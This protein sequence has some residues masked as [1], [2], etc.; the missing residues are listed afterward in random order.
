MNRILQA[1]LLISIVLSPAIGQEPDTARVFPQS[2]TALIL[3][4]PD[5]ARVDTA[6]VSYQLDSTRFARQLDSLRFAHQLDSL[7]TAY[8]LDS[9][10]TAHQLDSIRVSQRTDSLRVSQHSDSLRVSQRSDSTFQVAERDLRLADTLMVKEPDLSHSPYKAIMYA[11]VLPGLGQ[12]YNKRYF[13]IPIVY[14]ALGG[15]GYAIVFNTKM[16]RESSYNYALTPDNT[17]ERYIRYWRRNVELS[18]IGLILVY[19]LQVVDAYVDAQLYNWDVNE[20]LSLRVAP[21]LQP[22]MSPVSVNRHVYG[23]TCSIDF[24]RR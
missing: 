6:R 14:A 11:L 22:M 23:F 3:Q 10:R 17:N 15:V 13:K 19:A 24:K 20:N 9:I 18:Y 5:T 7:R 2:D 1:F 21:S 12:G 4:Q 8:R 16:Y